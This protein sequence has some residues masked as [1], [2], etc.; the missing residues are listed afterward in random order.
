MAARPA[1]LSQGQPNAFLAQRLAQNTYTAG[2]LA[3]RDTNFENDT[4]IGAPSAAYAVDDAG[5][6]PRRRA[7]FH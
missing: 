6:D 7:T 2:P 1:V 3:Q 4:R 5:S